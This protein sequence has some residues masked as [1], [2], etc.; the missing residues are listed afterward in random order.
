[1][2]NARMKAFEKE[3]QLRFNEGSVFADDGG[4][5]LSEKREKGAKVEF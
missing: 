5:F 2:I 3:L 1:M 4:V